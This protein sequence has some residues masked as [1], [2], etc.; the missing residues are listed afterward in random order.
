MREGYELYVTLKL[1]DFRLFDIIPS[2]TILR[3]IKKYEHP[4]L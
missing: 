4:K 1:I 3:V 2:S